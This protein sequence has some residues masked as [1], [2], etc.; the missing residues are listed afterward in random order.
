MKDKIQGIEP[1]SGI[2]KKFWLIL[3]FIALIGLFLY[4]SIEVIDPLQVGSNPAEQE[5]VSGTDYTS[6]R[7]SH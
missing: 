7:P 2:G 3:V 6:S 1:A 5:E 4:N